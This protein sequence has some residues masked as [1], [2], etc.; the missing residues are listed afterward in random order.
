[1]KKQEIPIN[2]PPVTEESED[3]EPDIFKA[4]KEGKL[5]SVQYLIEKQNADKEITGNGGK[6]PLHYA[7]EFGHLL[8][9][10]YLISKGADI[11]A[12]DIYYWTPL[13]FAC[14]EDHLEIVEYLISKGAD[15]EAK[16]WMDL[17]GPLHIASQYD[18]IDVVNC[19]VSKGANKHAKNDDDETPYDLVCEFH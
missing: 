15:I 3:Y 4:C 2:A 9:V 14:K 18:N 5:T 13:H 16:E 1:M 19:L 8:I 12:K 7:C 6:T 17:N 11:E 10:E